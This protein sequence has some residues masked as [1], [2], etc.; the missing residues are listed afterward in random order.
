MV[1]I[2]GH[3]LEHSLSP[4]I[5]N[6]AF[7]NLHLPW[8]YIPLEI[9]SSQIKDA[10]GVLRSFNS[11]GANVTVPYKEAVLPWLD[12]VEPEAR[13]LGSVNTIY[14]DG[15]KLFG[16]STDGKGFLRSLGSWRKKLRGSAGLLLGA[17]GAGK[18]VSGAL[19]RSGVKKLYVFDQ[20]EERATALVKLIRKRNRRIEIAE[21]SRQN[22]EK[23]LAG[24]DWV[25]QA[26]STG[27][28]KEDPSPLSL[29]FSRSQTWVVDLIY[30]HPTSFLLEAK[31]RHL[32]YLNGLGM[33]LH[34]GAL[35]FQR[36]T[37]R[38]AP[39]KIMKRALLSRLGLG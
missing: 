23:L 9:S 21:V 20:L 26:T 18:A 15:K 38:R 35:S 31:T 30:H 3:P 16:E 28:K 4:F 7:A 10:I 27:L 6:A 8:V 33:L 12:W 22:A 11:K 34:Q 37:G 2:L 29:N 25:I 1:F 13:W 32:P 14:R 24:C 19:S 39:V 5:H 36:W 17:G